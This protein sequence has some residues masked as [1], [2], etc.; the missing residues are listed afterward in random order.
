MAD[1]SPHSSRPLIEHGNTVL[2]RL[3]NGNVTSVKVEKDTTVNIGKFGA[4]H[5]NELIGQPFGLNHEIVSKKLKLLPP[6]T[7]QEIEETGATNELIVD[8][9]GVQPLTTEEIRALKQSGAHASDIIQKQV[10]N[11]ANFALKTEYSKEKYLKRKEAKYSKAFTTIEPT[12]FNVCEYWFN[13]D[14]WRIKDLRIDSLAQ[15]LNL[16][17]VRPGGRHLVVDDASGMVA[18]GI[19]TRL[20]GQGRLLAICDTESPPAFPVLTQMNLSKEQMEPLASLNWATSQKDYIPVMPPSELPAEEIRSERQKSRLKKRKA[21]NDHLNNTR[22]DLFSGGF[23]SLVVATEY[24]PLAIIDR[25]SPYL[26]GSASI[27]VH[28]PYIQVVADLQRKLRNRPEFL[29]P[30]VTEAWL[31]RYQVLPGRTH[32]MMAMSGSGGFI[33]HAIKM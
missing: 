9:Q 5:A 28:S 19:L 12:L 16:A 17:N 33:L 6:K 25:L 14:Q 24:D 15:I 31:R 20:G 2:L 3:P 32:P 4:F 21:L 8:Q 30:S 29:C 23:D 26:A 13:K 7:W 1:S 11:H 10:E 27:V 22:E 18:A